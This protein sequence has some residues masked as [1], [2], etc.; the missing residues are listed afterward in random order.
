MFNEKTKCY[1]CDVSVAQA[2]IY[3]QSVNYIMMPVYVQTLPKLILKF[4]AILL[5][6]S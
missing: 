1:F 3:F 4:D 6:K 5:A 2:D